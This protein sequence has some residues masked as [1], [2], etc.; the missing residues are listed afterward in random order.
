MKV[1]LFASL[2]ILSL[3]GV[4]QAHAATTFYSSDEVTGTG[5]SSRTAVDD[6]D[7]VWRSAAGEA[8]LCSDSFEIGSILSGDLPIIFNHGGVQVQVELLDMDGGAYFGGTLA[9]TQG[10]QASATSATM[11]DSSPKPQSLYAINEAYYNEISGAGSSLNGLLLTFSEPLNAYGS[12][13]GD[14][15]TR[16]DGGG[17]PAFVRLFDD[18]GVQI[19]ADEIIEPVPSDPAFDQSQCGAPSGDSFRGC[20]N[21]STRWVGFTADPSTLVKSM[22]V[23]V[24]DDDT[25]PGT[26]NGLTEHLSMMGAT[27]CAPRTHDLAIAKVDATDPVTRGENIEYTITITNNDTVNDAL[28]VVV[29]ENYDDVQTTFI[30]AIPTQG[31]CSTPTAGIFTCDIGAI[32]ADEEQS[33]VVTVSADGLGTATNT[34]TVTAD[35]IDSSPDDNQTSEPTE[36]VEET[37]PPIVDPPV[38]EPEPNPEPEPTPDPKPTP[39]PDSEVETPTTESCKDG[40]IGNRIWLDLNKNGKIDDG[41]PG[42][43]D[44][45]IKLKDDNGKT[46]EKDKTN[47][48]GK[49]NFEDLEPGD[50]RVVVDEDDV[51][52]Y[53]QTYDP[54]GAVMNNVSQV[55]LGCN[56]DINKVDFGYIAQ[57]Q[58]E[59]PQTL[60][61]TGGLNLWGRMLSLFQ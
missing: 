31:T 34:V 15:E 46:I 7:D 19:G 24:G 33:I 20:G 25:T 18:S 59:R 53:T 23:V 35:G 30:S 12:Y 43:E 28:N 27:T 16:T 17:T 47:S 4:L 54:N 37:D 14:V 45:S 57:N 11:Q 55:E 29:S 51:K 61:K 42:I 5:L 21:R 10:F 8:N 44:V 26:D 3:F 60:A 6:L 40:Q 52:D 13:F 50:Y 9:N 58:I 49:Y 48:Y 41:E 36:V 2:L 32:A 56:E 38:T 22:L 1:K 39:K